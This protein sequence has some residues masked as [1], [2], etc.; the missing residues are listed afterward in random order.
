MQDHTIVL[1]LLL[2]AG[3]AIWS[4]LDC[5]SYWSRNRIRSSFA[6]FV[7]I[8]ALVVL[9]FFTYSAGN[10]TAPTVTTSKL[11][12][13]VGQ[14]YAVIYEAKD[15]SG[16]RLLRYTTTVEAPPQFLF[17]TL[18]APVPERFIVAIDGKLLPIN[19]DAK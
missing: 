10:G 16:R 19:P 7:G 3:V 14:T 13:I 5:G 12:L 4:F 17:V 15:G 18:K 2:L 11:R 6:F 8:V 9:A 1:I